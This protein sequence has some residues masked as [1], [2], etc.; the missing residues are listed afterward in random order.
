M[1]ARVGEVKLTLVCRC[2]RIAENLDAQLPASAGECL[3]VSALAIAC[4]NTCTC[5]GA[6]HDPCSV[7]VPMSVHVCRWA[8]GQVAMLAYYMHPCTHADEG[9]GGHATT[10][11]RMEGL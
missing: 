8:G 10:C 4:F 1:L 3:L 9:T 11:R 5:A 2:C 6:L 7:R